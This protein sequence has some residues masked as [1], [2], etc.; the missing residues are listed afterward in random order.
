MPATLHR[1]FEGTIKT[2]TVSRTTTGKYFVSI[3]VDLPIKAAKPKPVNPATAVG[4]DRPAT[5]LGI[6]TFLVTSDGEEFDRAAGRNQK[7]LSRNL[8]RPGGEPLRVEQ[9]SLAR[10]QKGNQNREKQRLVVAKLHEKIRNQRSDYLHKLST[11]LLSR[12][13]TLCFEDLH[14][15]GMVKNRPL[16][17]SINEQGWAEFRRMCEYKAETYGKHVVQ[18]GRFKPSSKMCSTC[19]ATNHQLSLK[20]REW[21][22]HSC[23]AIH[24]RDVNAAVNIKDFGCR[25]VH[26]GSAPLSANVAH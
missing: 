22:C 7:F 21:T 1:K 26:G 2:T 14:I 19:G 12:Y 4:L 24:D 15:K 17:R 18:I 20:D 3:L 10:K 11:G 13:D 9:R 16:A 25:R 6:K 23:S 8:K 5:R